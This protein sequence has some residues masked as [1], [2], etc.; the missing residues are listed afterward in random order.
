MVSLVKAELALE[1]IL[2]DDISCCVVEV[3]DI[4]KGSRLIVALTREIDSV[5]VL[6]QLRQVL[7]PIEV[8]SSFMVFD[9]LPKMANGKTA[10][11]QITL[12]VRERL[13]FIPWILLC[14]FGVM[15]EYSKQVLISTC[16]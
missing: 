12:M 5:G 14:L 1:Q 6:K 2:P 10:F 13:N 9:E 11:R 3:P 7:A 8:P 4:R 15:I 16:F